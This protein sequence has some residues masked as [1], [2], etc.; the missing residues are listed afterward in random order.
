MALSL[1]GRLMKKKK[2]PETDFRILKTLTYNKEDPKIN[3]AT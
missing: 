1:T 2:S 3:R